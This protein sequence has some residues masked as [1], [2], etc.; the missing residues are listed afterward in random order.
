MKTRIFLTTVSI[1]L[2]A[3]L[4]ACSPAAAPTQAPQPTAQAIVST[5]VVAEAA[6]T[7]GSSYLPPA[8]QMIIKDATLEM[9]VD[10][11]DL[12]VA[13]ITQMTGDNGGYLISSQTWLVGESR[14]A[15]LQL[16]LP[17]ARFEVAL[18]TVKTFAAQVLKETTSGQDVSAEYTDLQSRLTNLEATAARVREFLDDAT[19][20]EESLRINAELSTLEGQIEQVTGQMNFYEGRA[21]YSTLNITLRQKTNAVIQVPGWDPATTAGRALKLL[22]TLAQV[23]LDL[24]IW[25][26]ILGG[27]FLLAG[28]LALAGLRLVLRKRRTG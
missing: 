19:T 23:G 6:T 7:S 11:V 24:L 3:A 12:A 22:T 8:N 18:N 14:N 26:A 21:A 13:Q 28:G 15:T 2:I 4:A 20:V 10:D 16:G 27:P 9:L 1:G 17:S 25:L 5:A